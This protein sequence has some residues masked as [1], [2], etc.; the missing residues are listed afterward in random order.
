[1]LFEYFACSLSF[2]DN[3]DLVVHVRLSHIYLTNFK[4]MEVDCDK[5]YNLFHSYRKHRLI[6][7]ETH[8]S[9]PNES[10]TDFLEEND[11][12]YGYS[13][14]FNFH[15]PDIPFYDDSESS[16]DESDHIPLNLSNSSTS[17]SFSEK[18]CLFLAKLH[19][20]RDLS[21]KRAGE[22]I[23]EVSTLLDSAIQD[24]RD[25]IQSKFEQL[26]KNSLDSF[27]INQILNKFLAS[28]TDFNT[29][30]KRFSHL[31]NTKR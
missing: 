19:S 6:K 11:L 26:K 14:D 16:S 22:I 10:D 18:V 25:K 5:T 2:E 15:N 20:H 7:H 8:L 24:I 23:T 30:A 12:A 4:S 3:K 29:E 13:N 17:H 28:F 31:K 21:R 1:M 9:T 27:E